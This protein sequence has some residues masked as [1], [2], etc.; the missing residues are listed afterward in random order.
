MLGIYFRLHGDFPANSDCS[1]RTC[2]E[3][4]EKGEVIGRISA[5]WGIPRI[6]RILGIRSRFPLPDKLWSRSVLDVV[7]ALVF[8]GLHDKINW[9][10]FLFFFVLVLVVVVVVLVLLLHHHHHHIIIVVIVITTISNI[11][12]RWSSTTE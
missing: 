8:D 11:L 6:R 1:L 10:L 9:F 3:S 12:R 2:T 5:I 7:D 4:T